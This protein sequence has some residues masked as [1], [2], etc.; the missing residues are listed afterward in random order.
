MKLAEDK[1]G[2]PHVISPEDLTSERP[3]ERSVM[4]YLAYFVREDSPGQKRLLG[5]LKEKIPEQRLADLSASW[6]DGKALGALTHTLSGGEFQAYEEFKSDSAVGNCKQAM[7]AAENLLGV[8]Q[9]LKPEEFA[10]P[11][12]N[13]IIRSTYLTQFLYATSHPKMVDMHTPEQAGSSNVAY[14]DIVCPEGVSGEVEAYTKSYTAGKTQADVESTGENQYRVSFPVENPEMYTLYVSVGDKRVKGSPFSFNLTPPDPNA[15]K[16]VN[17]IL[18][19]KAGIPALLLFD[20]AEAGKGSLTCNV[21]GET[22]G[23][24]L[25]SAEQMSP[26][27]SKV[28]FFPWENDV[29]NI[30]VNFN[31][32]RVKGSPFT[33]TIDNLLQPERVTVG[34]PEATDVGKPVTIPIDISKAGEANLIVKCVGEKAGEIETIP[35]LVDGQEKPTGVTFTPPI[36]DVYNVSIVFGSTEVEGSPI[37][38]NLIPPPPDPRKVRLSKPPSGALDAGQL[39]MIGF[40]TS[41][42]GKGELNATCTGKATGELEVQVKEISPNNHE[43]SFTPPSMDDY[44]LIVTWGGEQ[45]AGSPFRLN[46]VSKDHPNPKNVKVTGFPTPKDILIVGEEISFQVDTK[47]AGKGVLKVTVECAASRSNEQANKQQQQQQEAKKEP[48]DSGESGDNTKEAKDGGAEG[49]PK[50]TEEESSEVPTSPPPPPPPPPPPLP[51]S[52]GGQE[53]LEQPK[54]QDK[55]GEAQEQ[56]AEPAAAVDVPTSPAISTTPEPSEPIV[57]QSKDNPKIY[58]VTYKPTVSGEHTMKITWAGELLPSFP[59]VFNVIQPRLAHFGLPIKIELR[60]NY[61]RKHLKVQA[62][63]RKN[64][65]EYKVRM[66][67]IASGH[68]TLIF[69]PNEPGIYLLHVAT[70]EKKLDDSPYVIDY[71]RKLV[72]PDVVKVSGLGEK[73]YVGEPIMFTINAKDAGDGEVSVRRQSMGSVLSLDSTLTQGGDAISIHLQLNDDGTYS[74]VYT[75]TAPGEEHLDVQFGGVSIPGSPFP[76]SVLKKD[77]DAAAAVTADVP[78][79]SK[80]G[81]KKKK[82]GTISGFDLD[83]ERFLVG[84]TQKFKLHCEE[85]GEGKLDVTCKP[86]NAAETDVTTTTGDNSYWVEITPKKPGKHDIIVRYD[87][88]HIT[89]SPFRVLFLSRGDALKCSMVDP[90]SDCPTEIENEVVFCISTKGAG[91]GKLTATAKSISS[92]KEVPVTVTKFNSQ[93]H[94]HHV[95]FPPTEGLNYTLNVF[96]DELHIQGSPFRIALGD[97]SRC[98][99]SGDGLIKAWSQKWNKFSIDS[100][101]AGPGELSVTIEGEGLGGLDGENSRI[102]PNISQ[103]DD[104]HYE[105]AYQPSEVGNYWITIKWGSIEI[106]GSPFCIPCHRPL[107]PSQF[108]IEEIVTQTFLGKPAQITVN[109]NESIEEEDKLTVSVHSLQDERH[110]GEVVRSKDQSYTCTITPPSLGAY[111]VYILWDEKHI[112]ESPFDIENIP[113]PSGE[114]FTI[115]AAEAEHQLIAMKVHGP[116][117]VFR[118]GQLSATVQNTKTGDEPPVSI[119]KNSNEECLVQFKPVHGEGEHLVKIIYDDQDIQGSPFTLVS[120]DAS[121][122]YARGKGIQKA[123]VNKENKFAVFTENGGPGELRVEIEGEVQGEGDILVEPLVT[124]ASETCYDVSYFPTNSGLYKISVFWDI[125]QIPGSPFN[126]YCCDPNRY[127]I[128]K[129]PKHGTLGKPIKVPIKEISASPDEETLQIYVT[130]KEHQE[131]KLKGEVRKGND[132]SVIASIQ[133]PE[134]GKY[135]VH[136]LC[137]SFEIQGSPFKTKVMPPP[138]PEKVVASGPGLQDGKAGEPST[139]TVD[140][141]EAGH[142]YV[143]FQ[144]QGPK[145]GF[146]INLQQD[147]ENKDIIKGE[148]NPTYPGTYIVA[149]LWSGVHIPNSPFTVKVKDADPEI[150]TY[151]PEAQPTR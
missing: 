145:H 4:V 144:V 85:L 139:F 31:G 133:P 72:K 75:P 34:K 79:T 71:T 63:S 78:T 104:F 15:V 60:T 14:I 11:E 109:C 58:N 9:T 149:L 52:Q 32:Q 48:S 138:V 54:P 35:L 116:K 18:P 129:P 100:E 136:V 47:N 91:K 21:T 69:H 92:Q 45:V 143:S 61:K 50:P 23:E 59:K 17:T 83:N 121:Q 151:E 26:T 1:L 130:S 22:S 124:A 5:W 36:E 95:R 81:E 125:H 96:Y 120:T 76:V 142:G 13:T 19:K 53:Q 20:L 25:N 37:T 66:D 29:Y 137:N 106:P 147:A 28:S 123:A 38:V 44:D 141:S 108:A 140:V 80:S 93:K 105:V 119:T 135:A 94:H 148:Y 113:I 3:D 33:V 74:A 127:T 57:E 62:V 49:E 24:V 99:T 65:K 39:I 16:H 131:N 42:A 10:D 6:V 8:D 107:D 128:Q 115:E 117:Y 103:L 64:N 90:L 101:E 12:S 82:K 7:E 46:L 150:L 68:Y 40:D 88:K 41:K 146:K 30:H 97:A 122:C 102:E 118:Y 51:P 73:G 110:Q 2:I 89:G 86:H 112:P 87:G 111:K 134:L 98:R 55:P 27:S 126:V 77:G 84:T 70:K 67:K 56:K 132:G 43:V 114:Q